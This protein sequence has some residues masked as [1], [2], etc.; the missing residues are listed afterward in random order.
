[1]FLAES[2]FDLENFRKYT[3]I[4][5][6]GICEKVSRLEYPKQVS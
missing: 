3:P 2:A 1:M 4:P 5:L 6:L